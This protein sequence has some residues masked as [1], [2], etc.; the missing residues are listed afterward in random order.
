MSASQKKSLDFQQLQDDF[1]CLSN[2]DPGT[3]LPVPKWTVLSLVLI[4]VVLGGGFFFVQDQFDTLAAA[5]TKEVTLKSEYEEKKVQV[6]NLDLYRQQRD[7]LEKSFSALLKQLPNKTE[8]EALL[9]EVNQ[10][11]LGRG[12]QFELF[13]PQKEVPKDFY[14]M[15]PVKVKVNGVY[16]DLGTFAADV[17][18]LPRIVTLNNINIAPAQGMPGRLAMDMQ[19]RTFRYLSEE[20]QAQIQA[21]QG[22]KK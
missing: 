15:L 4:V 16:H 14:A 11:G 1:R 19:V 18:K 13:E 21:A 7:E 12:L 2:G 17:A 5:E 22:G 10:A 6:I 3:W 8:V 9:V 20:E